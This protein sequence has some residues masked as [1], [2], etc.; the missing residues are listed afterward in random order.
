MPQKITAAINAQ[1]QLVIS[2]E[3]VK[4]ELVS[5]ADPP[6]VD[7]PPVD[8][9]P[10]DPP[11][12][13]PPPAATSHIWVD[14]ATL[15]GKPRTGRG[16]NNMYSMAKGGAPGPVT[17]SDQNSMHSAWM[18]ACAYVYAA[19]GDT[20]FLNKVT[21][22]F[23]SLVSPSLPTVT[24]TLAPEEFEQ[25]TRLLDHM[26]ALWPGETIDDHINNLMGYAIAVLGPLHGEPLRAAMDALHFPPTTHQEACG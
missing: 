22:G 3:G 18:Q 20:A 1:G 17:V 24:A 15:P 13:D 7:P 8:P 14:V 11:P 6:P 9:P 16:W 26:E 25:L 2:G 19:T 10:V 12:V 5:V 21:T 4:F 23:K